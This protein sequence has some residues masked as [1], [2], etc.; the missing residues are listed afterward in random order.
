MKGYSW[1]S[2]SVWVLLVWWW[3]L[4][5]VVVVVVVEGTCSSGSHRGFTGQWPTDSNYVLVWS[6]EFDELC[7]DNWFFQTQVPLPDGWHNQ[8]EQLY[9]NQNTLVENGVLQIIAKREEYTMP[10]PYTTGTITKPFTS[11]RLNAKVALTYGKVQVRAKLPTNEAGLVPAIW[12]LGQDILEPGAYFYNETL[13]PYYQHVPWPYCGELDLAMGGWPSNTITASVHTALAYGQSAL[14]GSMDL[15]TA[16]TEFHEYTL[17]WE[18]TQVQFWVDETLVYTYE[19]PDEFTADTWPL[20]QPQYMLLSMAAGGVLGGPV[21]DEWMQATME[22]DHVRWYQR[23]SIPPPGSSYRTVSPPLISSLVQSVFSNLYESEVV[24]ESWNATGSNTKWQP[25]TDDSNN[26][27]VAFQRY[28]HLTTATIAFESPLDVSTMT[29]LH[30]SLWTPNATVS[31][32]KLGLVL[33]NNNNNDDSTGENGT[34]VLVSSSTPVAV[35]PH[36]QWNSYEWALADIWP[37]FVEASSS[38][39]N[40]GVWVSQL[41]IFSSSNPMTLYLDHLFFFRQVWEPETAAPT[42]LHAPNH[43]ISLFSD[44]YSDSVPVDS[45][46]TSWSAAA[47]SWEEL[48]LHNDAI[49]KYTD[50]AFAGIQAPPIDASNMTGLHLD[51]W[52][53]DMG[54]VLKVKVVDFGMNG[55]YQ[56]SNPMFNDDSEY[57]LRLDTT[58]TVVLR[59]GE[60]LSLDLPFSLFPGLTSRQHVTQI[61]L[62]GQHVEQFTLFLDNVYFYMD[63]PM[64]AAP[65]PTHDASQVLSL[66][67]DAYTSSVTVDTWKA[68]WSGY[69]VVLD[70]Q[71]QVVTGDSVKKY[72]SLTWIGVET[73]GLDA[74]SM[75]RLHLDLWTPEC[76][77]FR[78]KLT[79]FGSNG[80]FD[81]QGVPGSDDSEH[82][83]VLDPLTNKE[84]MSIDLPLSDFTNLQS[85]AHLAQF[86]FSADWMCTAY[87]DNLFLYYEEE[88]EEEEVVESQPTLAAPVESTLDPASDPTLVLFSSSLSYDHSVTVDSWAAPGL[89]V[90]SVVVVADDESSGS[91]GGSTETTTVL[92]FGGLGVATVAAVL[93]STELLSFFHVSLWT[94][95][96]SSFRITLRELDSTSESEESTAVGGGG[97]ISEEEVVA[98]FDLS[99][100]LREWVPLDIDL[101]SLGLT[102]SSSTETAVQIVLD[103]GGGSGTCTAFVDHVYLYQDPERRDRSL[104][105][106]QQ[107]HTTVDQPP[108]A[109]GGE[110]FLRQAAVT[111]N[112][113]HSVRGG[114]GTL[115]T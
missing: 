37:G 93:D 98:T 102:L 75:T 84:W 94:S 62:S 79:D 48:E 81:G 2:S 100:T 33:V 34:T 114:G 21:P 11:A 80:V 19:A 91:G 12:F 10:N 20:D 83:I 31:N 28:T 71:F 13:R 111:R 60:W 51:V 68:D 53:P 76:R 74:T 36:N 25:V 32:L 41:V 6:D 61:V 18:E 54:P 106:Q 49:M 27:E 9:T 89:S 14:R 45:W 104:L 30:V 105:Q 88:E 44:A 4:L 110:Q 63:E 46:L 65:V 57:D 55:V 108:L 87:L 35:A 115:Q 17:I 39:E 90:E 78:I 26:N 15:S 1:S 113:I 73:A 59:R 101:S 92:K 69:T 7:D 23:E 47:T 96:C 67:S 40:N 109:S 103:N 56:G 58:P 107:Q 24:V 95:D 85:R 82:E 66:F 29:H 38:S 70:D 77:I 22:I 3:S 52:S 112:A 86:I 5:S 64:E 43:V 99:A 50:F 8:E 42:P 72:T 97:T 16:A